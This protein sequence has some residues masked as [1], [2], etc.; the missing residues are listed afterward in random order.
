MR[1][2]SIAPNAHI[3][4]AIADFF[5]AVGLIAVAGE[6]GH[7]VSQFLQANSCVDNEPFCAAY[8]KVWVEEDDLTS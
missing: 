1:E 8:T 3:E 4:G 7:L 5:E 6:Y 2:D